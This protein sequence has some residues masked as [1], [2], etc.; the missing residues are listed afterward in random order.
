MNIQSKRRK[1]SE[2]ERIRMAESKERAKEARA[3]AREAAKV[4]GYLCC[5]TAKAELM[6]M[7]AQKQVEQ[8][9]LKEDREA[10]REKAK[11]DKLM[12]K[13]QSSFMRE[14]C[15]RAGVDGIGDLHLYYLWAEC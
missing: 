8:E 13:R 14:V 11:T 2:E 12:Q 5:M 10:K 4:G 9:M 7:Q 6:C 15:L 3:R 1:V